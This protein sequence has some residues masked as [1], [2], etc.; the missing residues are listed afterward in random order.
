MPVIVSL[1]IHTDREQQQMMV[2]IMRECW[3]PYLVDSYVN[4]D[5]Q[6]PL[7]SLESLRKKIL[8]KV[9]HSPAKPRR[10]KVASHGADSS[11]D[12]QLVEAVKKGKII[13]A[14]GSMGTYTRAC[15]FKSFSQ[16]EAKLPTH[17]FALSEGKLVDVHKTDPTALFRH[18]KTYLMRAYPKGL[19]VS[20]SNLDPAPLWRQGVQMVALNWQYVN[21]ANML[22]MAMFEGT[23]GWVLKPSHYRDPA[24][25]SS[26]SSPRGTLNLTLELF[27]AQSLPL[28][29]HTMRPHIRCDLHVDQI[30]SRSDT[31]SVDAI[32]A[33]DGEFKAHSSNGNSSQDPDFKRQKLIFKDIQG[34][35]EELSFVRSV[36]VT[37][38]VMFGLC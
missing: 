16:P 25:T 33:K 18:N 37:R 22:G 10:T 27:A 9:K 32:L 19:R 5:D 12:E 26:V 20:S 24:A 21:A 30:F 2:N 6:V 1:E 3:G 17:V 14:L 36:D 38:A 35:T 8:I 34:I 13:E 28:A 29:S 15:H 31:A 7:P 4:F 23:P 11:D